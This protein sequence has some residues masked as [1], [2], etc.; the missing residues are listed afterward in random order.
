MLFLML[1]DLSFQ[2]QDKIPGEEGL[3]ELSEFITDDGFV[4][5]D[6]LLKNPEKL[7][8]NFRMIL[9]YSSLEGKTG[10]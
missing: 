9:E 4:K 6:D 1:F 10:S 2:E 3:V 5:Y 7:D 8:H